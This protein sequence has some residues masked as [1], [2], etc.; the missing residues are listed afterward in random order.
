MTQH[1]EALFGVVR[2]WLAEPGWSTE[3]IKAFDAALDAAGV[4]WDDEVAE[5]HP[6]GLTVRGAIE[7]IGHEAIVREAYKDSVGV[8]TW[9][10]GVTNASGHNVDRYK[11]SPQPV[12]KCL[13]VF[14]WLLRTRYIPAVE[15]AFS[16][17]ALNEAQFAAALSFHYNTGAIASADWVKQWKQ[18]EIAQARTAFMNWR[19]PASIIPRREK[20][21][22]LFFDGRWSGDGKATVYPV[23]K[24]SYQ[25]DFRK[26]QRIDVTADVA[27]LIGGAVP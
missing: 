23:L 3:R 14:V 6:G 27:A 26:P 12:A 16:G 15:A 18:G 24:P 25:P 10:I 13:E 22:D 4:P 11:D 17:H 2:P 19:K 9:G 1:R 20:E 7:L 8:W 21:R 5:A